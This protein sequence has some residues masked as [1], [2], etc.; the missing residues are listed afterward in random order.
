MIF[1][2]PKECNN[3]K[4]IFFKVLLNSGIIIDMKKDNVLYESLLLL[5]E[6]YNIFE[7]R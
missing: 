6:Y 1:S 4:K 3:I 7:M 2:T 5:Q